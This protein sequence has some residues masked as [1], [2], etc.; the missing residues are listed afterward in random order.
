[1][2]FYIIKYNF[3]TIVIQYEKEKRKESRRKGRWIDKGRDK[4]R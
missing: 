3:K 2:L 4:R 1:M